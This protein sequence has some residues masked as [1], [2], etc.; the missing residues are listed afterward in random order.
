MR[1]LET[2]LSSRWILKSRDREA[3]YQMKEALASG[4]EKKFLMEKMGYQ[5]LVNP[6]M[7][8]VEKM[9]AIP[10]NWMGILEFREPIEY[11][12]FC[13]VLMFLEDKEAQEQFVLSELTEYVQSQYDQEQIDWTVYRYRR[14]MIKVMKYCVSCGILNVDDGSEEGFARDDASEVLYENT[15]A[16]RYFM[17][18]FTQDIMGYTTPKDF[19]REEWIDVN[20]D[21]GI[22]RRQR[23]YRKLLMSMGMYKSA[24]TEEDFAYVRNYRNMIQSEL[25]ELF[26]CELQVHKSSA[27]LVLGE[28]CRLGRCFPEENT[29]S[30]I[31]LLVFQVI[32][33][34][35][36][37]GRI[38]VPLD[39]QIRIPK[40]AFRGMVDECKERFGHGLNKTYREM[41]FAEFYREV[42][43]YMQEL[44]LIEEAYDEVKIKPVAGKI[45]GKYPDDFLKN[46]GRD[47]Q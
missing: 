47:E 23:V 20:E 18:N 40:E 19:E 33:E 43:A 41:T 2:L 17:K 1:T 8:K 34:K 39:E 13:I 6:Y 30:D 7:I 14:H 38:Q 46:G 27:Y 35:V 15:G 42:S 3:Y 12:F 4:E 28:G 44:A 21:R 26:D 22:V 25:T 32:Q 11:M 5:V 36:S 29:L 37:A 24:D 45:L 9:P 31:V 16:S 10:E